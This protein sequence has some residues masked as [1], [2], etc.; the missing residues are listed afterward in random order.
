VALV[1]ISPEAALRRV[2]TATREYKEAYA[3]RNAAV[4][5]ADECGVT[6]EQIAV[7]ASLATDEVARIIATKGR[8]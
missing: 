1:T 4:R 8:A 2:E 7:T 5:R 6:K 3:R